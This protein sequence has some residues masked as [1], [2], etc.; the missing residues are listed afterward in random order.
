MN[1]AMANRDGKALSALLAPSYSSVDI[2]GD[3]ENADYALQSMKKLPIDPHQTSTT[4]L[5]SITPDA[6]TAVVEQRYDVKSVKFG[7]D[8]ASRSTELVST[9]TDTWVNLNGAWLIQRTVIKQ[10][11]YF[12][13]GKLVKHQD[14]K[15]QP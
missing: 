11:D 3:T 8:G 10:F 2:S 12:V 1:A 14:A 4:T 5:L 9:S 13:N 6:N 15:T 7:P